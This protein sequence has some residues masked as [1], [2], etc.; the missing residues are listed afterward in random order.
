[1]LDSHNDVLSTPRSNMKLVFS[2]GSLL[3]SLSPL[4]GAAENPT[5]QNQVQSA[6]MVLPLESPA[7][8]PRG[9]LRLR[10]AF[11]YS[12]SDSVAEEVKPFRL[13]AEERQR[14]RE[15]LRN[16]SFDHQPRK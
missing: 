13:S 2:L 10:D 5:H 8:E 14:L 12:D 1:M 6:A 3:L 4:V 16:Q 11:R 7:G 15:Q 9:P